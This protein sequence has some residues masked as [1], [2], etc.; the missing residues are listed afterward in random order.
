MCETSQQ[1]GNREGRRSSKSIAEGTTELGTRVKALTLL[2]S[3]AKFATSAV[4][5]MVANSIDL[6]PLLLRS[7]VCSRVSFDISCCGC[8]Q[9]HVR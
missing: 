9:D 2:K 4:V 8:R 7:K 5:A 6:L 1:H 3:R